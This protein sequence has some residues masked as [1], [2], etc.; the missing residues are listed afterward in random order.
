MS[1]YVIREEEEKARKKKHIASRG[2]HSSS[3]SALFFFSHNV[4]SNY[5][6]NKTRDFNFNY[7]TLACINTQRFVKTFL[8][9]GF[10]LVS[11]NNS[12]NSKKY[13]FLIE[14]ACI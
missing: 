14:V 10:R 8:Y 13:A 9:K 2:L 5:D 1:L 12:V 3:S 6:T 11:K 4:L 7:K